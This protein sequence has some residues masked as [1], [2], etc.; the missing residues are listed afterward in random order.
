[1]EGQ[2][3]YGLT[4]FIIKYFR[5]E[6]LFNIDAFLAMEFEQYCKFKEM[7]DHFNGDDYGDNLEKTEFNQE[8]DW[9]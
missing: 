3:F 7:A 6:M 4:M 1:M 9:S 5:E 2:M 8:P